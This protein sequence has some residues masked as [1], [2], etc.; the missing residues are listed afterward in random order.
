MT[1][2]NKWQKIFILIFL[3]ICVSSQYLKSISN[4]LS[5]CRQCSPSDPSSCL[6]K[7]SDT[8]CVTGFMY[9]QETKLCVLRPSFEVYFMFIYLFSR[10]MFHI[11]LR[12]LQKFQTNHNKSKKVHGKIVNKHNVLLLTQMNN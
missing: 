5:D 3:V 2:K 4:C 8:A 10:T 7:D 9:G 6:V 11:N 1:F 12:I